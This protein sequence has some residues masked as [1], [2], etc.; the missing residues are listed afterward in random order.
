MY[1]VVFS[2]VKSDVHNVSGEFIVSGLGIY[3][4]NIKH[5][6]VNTALQVFGKK[7]TTT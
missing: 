3:N 1:I 5:G 2:K 6:T 7:L 4:L